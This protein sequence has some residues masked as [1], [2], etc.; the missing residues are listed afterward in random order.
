MVMK[1]KV[2]AYPDE[3]GRRSI[4]FLDRLVVFILISGMLFGS[5]CSR[6]YV[7]TEKQGKNKE[8]KKGKDKQMVRQRLHRGHL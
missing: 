8:N 3:A 1:R 2:A 5:A 7:E 6:V 4:G